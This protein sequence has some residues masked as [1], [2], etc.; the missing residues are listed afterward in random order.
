MNLQLYH[1]N[2]VRNDNWLSNLRFLCPNCHSQTETFCSKNLKSKKIAALN[3]SFLQ[4]YEI[5]DL[6][7]TNS[8]D[9]WLKLNPF[10]EAQLFYM[11]R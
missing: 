8:L 1:I 10:Y 9:I 3:P 2:C 11:T 4:W 7:H 5:V 6:A